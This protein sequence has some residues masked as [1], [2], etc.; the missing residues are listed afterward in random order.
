M[1][2]NH[3][4]ASKVIIRVSVLFLVV[5]II[6]TIG[7][8]L[9]VYSRTVSD[10]QLFSKAVLDIYGAMIEMN[11]RTEM[12][13][14]DVEHASSVSSC[15]Q[16]ICTN[17][18]ID[19]AYVYIPNPEN[20]TV[21]YIDMTRSF[22]KTDSSKIGI[23]SMTADGIPYSS[24]DHLKG[25]VAEYTLSD[26]EQA[27]WDG[28]EKYANIIM[29]NSFGHEIC[30]ISR[31]TDCYGNHV[32]AGVDISY[33]SVFYEISR[34]FLLLNG[35]VVAVVVALIIGLYIIIRARVFRPAQKISET[36]NA[37]ITDGKRS[38]VKLKIKG[39]DE[40]AM[41]SKAFNS[42][43]EDIDNYVESI[44]TLNREQA[45]Q[46]AEMDVM[47]SIQKGFLPGPDY[48]DGQFEIHA[49]MAPAKEIGGDLYDYYRID[50]D[51]TLLVVADVSGKGIPAAMFMST[52][53]TTFRQFAKMNKTPAEILYSTNLVLAENNAESLFVTAFVGIFDRRT[54]EFTYSNAGH[55]LPYLLKGNTP[56]PIEN[57]RGLLL[58]LFEDEEYEQ[59]VLQLGPGDALFLYTDGVNEAAD[60]EGK[61]FGDDRLAQTL[62]AVRRSRDT[63]AVRTVLQTIR[64]FTGEAEQN[65]DITMLYFR[66]KESTEL[67]LDVKPT[68]FL[69]IKEAIMGC[70]APEE[71]RLPMC[72][73]AE[74]LFV[75]IVSY[76]FPEGVPEDEKIRF[77]MEISD[78]MTMRLEDGGIPYDPLEKVITPEEYDIDTQIGGLGKLISFS[79]ADESD[80]RYEN[81][82]NIV[83]ITK[84]LQEDHENDHHEDR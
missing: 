19:Y 18:E 53:V 2:K 69:R 6:L 27:V 42:M 56:V 9:L 70:S 64:D 36:M 28:T 57:A 23:A 22:S 45:T 3:S 82:K 59:E 20:D 34:D 75:N 52:T 10:T 62:E 24:T 13:P 50:A 30:T 60:V 1:R 66:I 72:L 43:T 76:A 68:E 67:S 46:K 74:E 17:Y 16:F 4:I 25:M 33:T 61:F 7:V 81:Q 51:R 29:M 71:I 21:T 47:A 77:T 14:I 38:N 12:I 80:Y 35:I 15:G 11:S 79:I 39:T 5:L 48:A 83:T 73:V 54:G 84:Y 78:K 41:I 44:R 40:F 65:D 32:L 31:L 8:Y 49:V 37:F 58:G 63:E 26:E 55:N